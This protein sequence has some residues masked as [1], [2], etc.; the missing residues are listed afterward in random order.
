M[1]KKPLQQ[2]RLKK[3]KTP[4]INVEN[5]ASI[6]KCPQKMKLIEDT[7]QEDLNYKNKLTAKKHTEI[8]S[9]RAFELQQMSYIFNFVLF[10]RREDQKCLRMTSLSVVLMTNT[11]RSYFILLTI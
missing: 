5:M 7:S 4:K 10:A 1:G 9:I 11:T 6:K 3:R 8:D 2:L